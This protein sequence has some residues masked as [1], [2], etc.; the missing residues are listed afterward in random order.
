MPGGHRRFLEAVESSSG[1]QS[2]AMEKPEGHPTRKAYETAVSALSALRTFH[3]QLVTRYIITP[4]RMVV[5]WQSKKQL[6]L[7]TASS[8]EAKACGAQ[9]VGEKALQKAVPHG[10]GA[11]GQSLQLHGTG[12]TRLIPFLRQCRDETNEAVMK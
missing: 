7:A 11:A 9:V 8:A 5:P 12:G 4:S 2:Y 10:D 6:N 3:I 1:V